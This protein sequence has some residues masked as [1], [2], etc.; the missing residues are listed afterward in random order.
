MQHNAVDYKFILVAESVIS[1]AQR[2]WTRSHIDILSK[3]VGYSETWSSSASWRWVGVSEW[4]A[5]TRAAH[6]VQVTGLRAVPVP[7]SYPRTLLLRTPLWHPRASS[8]ECRSAHKQCGPIRGDCSRDPLRLSGPP[9]IG[10]KAG[11][12]CLGP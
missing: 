8:P 4:R 12:P 11:N 10:T 9:R 2:I 3:S 7:N 6:C 5:C 1:Q